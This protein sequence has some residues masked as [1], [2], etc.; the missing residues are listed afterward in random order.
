MSINIQPSSA[1]PKNP[2]SNAAAVTTAAN[3]SAA[4]SSSKLDISRQITPAEMAFQAKL[5]NDKKKATAIERVKAV[6]ENEDESIITT[7]HALAKKLEALSEL[8][9]RQAGL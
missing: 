2:Q 6:T 3:F 4:L 8:E 1:M 9:R 5:K 7:V